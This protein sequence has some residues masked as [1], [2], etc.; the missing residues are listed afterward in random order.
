VS[1][2]GWDIQNLI[3]GDKGG[4]AALY[5]VSA[6]GSIHIVD[7]REEGNDRL[8]LYAGVS[9]TAYPISSSVTT[10]QYTFRDLGRKKFSAY[11]LHVESSSSES[12][13]GTI[14]IELEN[15]DATETLSTFAALAGTALPVA[16]DASLRGRIGNKRGYGAQLTIVPT[17]GR[18]KLRAVKMSAALTDP[19]IS[20]K[21]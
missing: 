6:N 8:S 12:S 10:R 7:E 21:T 18:P 4:A 15:P 1:E 9:A 17:N 13:D 2:A 5:T 11:E 20:S 19:T 14:S 16:E 3:V